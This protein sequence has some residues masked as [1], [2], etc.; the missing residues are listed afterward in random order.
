MWSFPPTRT[1][2]R[3]IR[4]FF[5]LAQYLLGV[6]PIAK[7]YAQSNPPHIRSGTTNRVPDFAI[8]F[9]YELRDAWEIRVHHIARSVDCR[10]Q[11]FMRLARLP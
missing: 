7:C 1:S 5:E 2:S 8:A 4:P 11:A 9:G 6:R 10:T 3:S